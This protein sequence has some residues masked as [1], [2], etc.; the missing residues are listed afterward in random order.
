MCARCPA[1][2]WGE[3]KYKWRPLTG[4]VL[5]GHV[6]MV[7][8]I[9][10]TE[11]CILNS[12]RITDKLFLRCFFVTK[13]TPK[14]T[15]KSILNVGET[16]ITWQITHNRAV[17]VPTFYPLFCDF[18]RSA[19]SDVEAHV[20]L[21]ETR[22]ISKYRLCYSGSPPLTTWTGVCCAVRNKRLLKGSV[23]PLTQSQRNGP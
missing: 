4:A 16:A 18:V 10:P 20:L 12:N 15:K 5:W 19:W 7:L 1:G 2:K 14:K 11:T 23:E 8:C 17:Y 22:D 3:E 9:Y 6:W 13:K 21:R